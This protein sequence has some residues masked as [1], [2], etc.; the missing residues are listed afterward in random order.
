[1]TKIEG[2]I[3]CPSLFI[4]IIDMDKSKYVTLEELEKFFSVIDSQR[5]RALFLTIYHYGL[6]VGE[7]TKLDLDDV[8]FKARKITIHRIRRREDL[9]RTKELLPKVMGDLKTYVHRLRPNKDEKAL[10]L[11]REGRISKRMVEILF[12][13]YCHKAGIE[14]DHGKNVHVLRHSL[15]IHKKEVGIPLEIIKEDLGHKRLSTTVSLYAE[16]SD[17]KIE[18]EHKEKVL[19]DHPSYSYRKT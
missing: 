3:D 4:W 5:D 8:D 6:R 1:M 17:K 7:A 19:T 13:R 2:D 12:R 11:S 18:E 9:I 10:F 14:L 15:A 16:H